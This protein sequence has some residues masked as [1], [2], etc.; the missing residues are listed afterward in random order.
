MFSQ[1]GPH[2]CHSGP[3]YLQLVAFIVA[4]T[5]ITQ[6]IVRKRLL[7]AHWMQANAERHAF[8][9]SCPDAF[10][11]MDTD[12]KIE[13]ANQ[14]VT[15]MFGYAVDEVMGKTASFLLPG[16]GHAQSTAGEF[17]ARRKGGEVFAVET[18]CGQMASTTTLFIRDITRR[19]EFKENLKTAGRICAILCSP[20]ALNSSVPCGP[21]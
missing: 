1:F 4:S 13:F 2:I 11:M 21:C 16:F 17:I 5:V 6:V 18:R 12:L 19:K 14:I 20:S 3:S 9:D 15:K 8:A 10:L 7:A